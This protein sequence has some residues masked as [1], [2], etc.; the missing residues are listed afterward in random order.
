M[1]AELG[2]VPSPLAVARHYLGLIQGFVLDEQDQEF[3]DPVAA[4][5]IL[6]LAT[7]TMMPGQAERLLLAGAVLEFGRNVKSKYGAAE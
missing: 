7:D 6:P 5:G 2:I 3:V 1:Y 4:E